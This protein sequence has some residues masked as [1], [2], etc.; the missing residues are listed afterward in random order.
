MIYA[1]GNNVFGAFGDA[2]GAVRTPQRLPGDRVLHHAWS[3][4]LVASDAPSEPSS[5]RP[6]SAPNGSEESPTVIGLGHWSFDEF[7]QA[8]NAS[9]PGV[10]ARF[11]AAG[12]VLAPR[13]FEGFVDTEEGGYYALEEGSFRRHGKWTSVHRFHGGVVATRGECTGCDP[14]W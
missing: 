14:R 8:L 9:P 6:S 10:R 4:V 13:D 1:L 3:G 5:P 11:F 7:A 12:D 2:Y